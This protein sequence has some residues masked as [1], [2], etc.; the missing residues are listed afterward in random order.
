[1]IRL[2]NLKGLVTVTAWNSKEAI[3][4]W[5]R[6]ERENDHLGEWR[7]IVCTDEPSVVWKLL[8]RMNQTCGGLPFF[9]EV[10]ADFF[11][12]SHDIM[13]RGTEFEGRP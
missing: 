13:Q 12:F 1:M 5:V 2:L 4:R 8:P 7:T 9:S 11:K 3:D 10:L 6:G